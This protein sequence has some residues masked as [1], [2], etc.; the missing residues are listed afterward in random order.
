L[1]IKDEKYRFNIYGCTDCGT[2]FKDNELTDS[3]I[4]IIPPNGK[5]DYVE[6]ISE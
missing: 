2:V 4:T 3:G 1:G 5:N 6:R